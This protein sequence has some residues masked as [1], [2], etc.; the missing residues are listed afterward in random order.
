[1]Y[2]FS[3]VDRIQPEFILS[4]SQYGFT[5]LITAANFGKCDVVIE[6]LDNGAHIDAQTNVS[7]SPCDVLSI[8]KVY[9]SERDMC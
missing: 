4:T 5:P 6:L 2:N 7:H 1:M 3:L 8:L 9:V